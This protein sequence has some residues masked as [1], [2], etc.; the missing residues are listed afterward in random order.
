M[1]HGDRWQARPG[2][3]RIG[4][5]NIIFSPDSRRVAYVAQ[6]GNN[7]FMVVDG[8][9]GPAYNALWDADFSPDSRHVAYEGRQG[10]RWLGDRRWE[11]RPSL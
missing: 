8:K 2:H 1:V 10:D 5:Y 4:G 11:A 6:R 7:W 9:P 3:N